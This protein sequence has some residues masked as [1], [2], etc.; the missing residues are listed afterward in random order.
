MLSDRYGPHPGADLGRSCCFAS[1][2]GSAPSPR[3]TCIAVYRT[4]AG[5][6]S[7][8][9]SD[10]GMTLAAEDL[11]GTCGRG[12]VTG[13]L[14]LSDEHSWPPSA[15][16]RCCMPLERLA[17]HARGRADPGASVN[18][19]R[20]WWEPAIF[21]WIDRR[22]ASALLEQLVKRRGTCRIRSARASSRGA[23][24]WRRRAACIGCRPTSPAGSVQ[25]H[26]DPRPGR[27]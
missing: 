14:E 8:A 2:P 1:S 27:R 20:R 13:G 26:A 22:P 4:I 21:P 23:E 7:G 17:R 12:F 6:G 24:L 15:T 25:P 18:L 3:A 9:S 11:A 10:I 16:C 19:V 5:L